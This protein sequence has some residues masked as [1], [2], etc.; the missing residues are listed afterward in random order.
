L[1]E[2]NRLVATGS[3]VRLRLAGDERLVAFV[4]RGD[5]AA[6]ETLYERHVGELMS[7]CVYMLGSRHDAEDA[8]QMTFTSAYRALRADRRPVTLRPWLFAIARNDCLTI[9]RRRRPWSELNGEPALGP[10]PVRELELHEEV[11]QLLNG[12]RELPERQR[13]ALVLAELHGLSQSEIGGVLGVRTDQVK[14]YVY[15]ARSNLISERRARDSDCRD[16]R[17]E[18]AGARGATLLKGQL[19]R[20]LRSCDDCRVYA[21]GVASRR[22]HLGALLPLAPS[23]ALKYRAIEDAIGLAASDPANYAGGVAAGG[24]ALAGTAVEVAGGGIKA[25]AVKVAAGMA[26]IGAS[27]GV[28]ASV[29]STPPA[30]PKGAAVA[31]VAAGPTSVSSRVSAG[32]GA[33]ELLAGLPRSSPSAGARLRHGDGT[34]TSSGPEV[35]GPDVADQRGGSGAGQRSGGGGQPREPRGGSERGGGGGRELGARLHSGRA[36]RAV[37]RSGRQGE[38]DSA[39]AEH[40]VAHEQDKS[41][42]AQRQTENA[43][44]RAKAHEER[45]RARAERHPEGHS[46]APPSEAELM[47]IREEH[48]KKHAE[49]LEHRKAVQEEGTGTPTPTPRP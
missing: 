35:I 14:A 37:Q 21:E 40:R 27:A 7:F 16:I 44:A 2:R 9:I 33:V 11:G 36:D 1:T 46:K 26:A 39:S 48:E 49:R 45:V 30:T 25:L 42:S 24:A 15:Q 29:L 38:R 43:A 6:F 17:E 31:D 34:S 23:L 20:H 4:R 5:R 47:R 19:R 8:L 32:S 12:L 13:A 10:D 28:G 22:H 41:A 3:R 18:L